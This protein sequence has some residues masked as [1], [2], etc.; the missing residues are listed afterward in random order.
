V[1]IRRVALVVGQLHTGGAERQLYELATRL[2]PERF[3]PLVVCLSEVSEPW[4]GRL[5]ARG[6]E[7]EVLRRARSRDMGRVL[8]LAR[9]LRGRRVALAHSFLLAANAYTWAATR[10]GGGIPYIASSRTC[11]PPVDRWSWRVHRRAFRRARAVIVNARGVGE[12][13]RHLYGLRAE[14]LRVI[15]NGVALEAFAGAA[16]RG[17]VLRAQWGVADGAAV[18]GTL[19]RLSPEKNLAVFLR[20]AALLRPRRAGDGWRCVVVGEGP[21]RP[22]LEDLAASLGLGGRVIFAGEQDDVAA[23]LAAM[24]LFVMTSDT[25]GMPNAVLEAMAAGLPVVATRVGGTPEVVVPGETGYL[26]PR[27]DAE[28]MAGRVAALLD[29]PGERRRLGEAGR[30]RVTRDFS[31]ETMVRAT[32]ALYEEVLA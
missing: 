9:L 20:M 15:P 19:G 23:A 4:A 7:V 12:F 21:A 17:A 28:G 31:A 5:R 8:S 24:D 13:T 14:L 26:L 2:D 3:E 25:E 1:T 18:I 6:V 22:G 29:D 11:I 10:L 27:R 30:E 32:C 16:G